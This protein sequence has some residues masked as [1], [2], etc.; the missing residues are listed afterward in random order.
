MEYAEAGVHERQEEQQILDEEY[1]CLGQV[2]SPNLPKCVGDTP[3][4]LLPPLQVEVGL[5]LARSVIAGLL[6]P[7][8]GR[9]VCSLCICHLST[10]GTRPV[11]RQWMDRR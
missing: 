9:Q 4:H 11:V 1:P 6:V 3:S 10:Q 2:L 8:P 5:R 7:V